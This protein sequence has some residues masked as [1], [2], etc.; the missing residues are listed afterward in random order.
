MYRRQ[1]LR[2]SALILS[3]VA[4]QTHGTTSI[5]VEA[6]LVEVRYVLVNLPVN[7]NVW[8]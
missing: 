5:H 6:A 2:S 8:R 3:G 4:R 1:C 7:D